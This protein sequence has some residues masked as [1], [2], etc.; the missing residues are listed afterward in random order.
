[1]AHHSAERLSTQAGPGT[2]ARGPPRPGGARRAALRSSSGHIASCGCWR[3]DPAHSAAGAGA[4]KRSKE[5]R[6]RAITAVLLGCAPRQPEDAARTD[7]RRAG[8]FT[9][10]AT[11]AA[12]RA[13]TAGAVG[14]VTGHIA[15]AISDGACW[16][17]LRVLGADGVSRAA[18]SGDKCLRSSAQS[19]EG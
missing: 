10:E 11:V 18:C 4:P 3:G 8:G 15:S 19:A 17:A 14:V 6:D 12:R 13:I 16:R 1:M 5:L 9:P 7:G 2:L